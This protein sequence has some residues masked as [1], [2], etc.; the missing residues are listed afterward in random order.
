[1]GITS[2]TEGLHGRYDTNP[3]NNTLVRIVRIFSYDKNTQGNLK[4]TMWSLLLWD[5]G[6]AKIKKGIGH[7]YELRGQTL[8]INFSVCFFFALQRQFC[9]NCFYPVH[10]DSL[11]IIFLKGFPQDGNSWWRNLWLRTSV[12]R[13]RRLNWEWVIERRTVR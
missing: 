10:R 3:L 2:F 6:L 1:M 12:V 13:Q 8:E 11:I 5:V 9:R 7:L 4:Q